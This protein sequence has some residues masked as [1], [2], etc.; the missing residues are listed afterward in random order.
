MRSMWERRLLSALIVI[1][2]A[3]LGAMLDIRGYA[4]FAY[5]GASVFLAM[6]L[7]VLFQ[8]RV[9]ARQRARLH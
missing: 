9:Q 5:L 3:A 4:V 7:G 1:G 6:I 2:L 8:A